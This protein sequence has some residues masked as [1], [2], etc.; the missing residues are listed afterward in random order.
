MNL[1]ANSNYLDFYSFRGS[2]L[3]NAPKSYQKFIQSKEIKKSQIKPI[4]LED[5]QYQRKSK[6]IKINTKN[7]KIFKLFF[8]VKSAFG[9]FVLGNN[10]KIILIY[11]RNIF[12]TILN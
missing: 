8:Y 4:Q 7:L 9:R 11:N 10:R 3:I 2:L 12:E 6:I 1:L 5:Q